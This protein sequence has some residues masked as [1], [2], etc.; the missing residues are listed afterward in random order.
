MRTKWDQF[1][2]GVEDMRPYGDSRTYVLGADFLKGFSV[3]D[4][5]CGLGWFSRYHQGAYIGADGS[6]SKFATV[7]ADLT[8][9]TSKTDGLFMRHILEHNHEWRKVLENALKSFQKRMVLVMFTPFSDETNVIQESVPGIPDIS[10]RKEDLVE[11]FRSLIAREES[12]KTA[13]QYGY[14]HVFYLEKP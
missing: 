3:E 7:S 10:F 14:E 2:K 9:Y 11:C 1:Y 6:C 13:T 4:W 5:G 8:E 12:L